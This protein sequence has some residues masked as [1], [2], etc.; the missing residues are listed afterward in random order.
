MV[1]TQYHCIIFKHV[2]KQLIHILSMLLYYL[3]TVSRKAFKNKVFSI[4]NII[5]LTIGITCCIIAFLYLQDEL[6]YDKHFKNIENVYRLTGNNFNGMDYQSNQPVRFMQEIEQNIPEIKESLCI[7]ENPG[8]NVGLENKFRIENNYMWAGQNFFT[9]LQ[10]ELIRGRPDEVL[11]MPYSVTISE[12]KARE[13][14]GDKDPIGQILRIDNEYNVT[15]TGVFK[16]FPEQSHISADFIESTLTFKETRKSYFTS[17]GWFSSFL[18][19]KTI[20]LANTKVVNEKITKLWHASSQGGSQKASV[21]ISLQRFSDIYLRSGSLNAEQQYGDIYKVIGFALIAA[22][23]LII[24]CFNFIN[25]SIAI[26]GQRSVES[27]VKKT[28]GAGKRFLSGQIVAEVTFYATVSLILSQF[29]ITVILPTFNNFTGKHLNSF[30]F[31]NYQLTI[32]IILLTVVIIT[33]TSSFPAS[34]L[35]K[36]NTASILKCNNIFNHYKGR[37]LL[38]PKNNLQSSLVTFQFF[39]GIFLVL[40]VIIINKQL[41]FIRT[42]EIGF[43][44]EQI[45]V[46]ENYEKN[47][48]KNYE[49]FKQQ[50]RKYPEVQMISSGINVP[51]DGVWN[52]GG[53]QLFNNP[54]KQVSGCGFVFVDYNYLTLLGTK[55]LKGR[56]FI[57]G[58]NTDLDKVIVTNTFANQL[59]I[60]QPIGARLTN[61]FDDKD[62]EIIGVVED[63]EFKSAHDKMKPI[64]FTCQTNFYTRLILI[65]LQTNNLLS[66]VNAIKKTWNDIVPESP[67][68]YSFMDEKFNKNYKKEMQTAIVINALTVIA[69]FLCCMGLFALVLFTINSK[70]KEIGIRRVNGAKIW[71]IMVL[72]NKNFIQGVIIAFILACPIAWYA[73]NKWLQRFAYRTELNWWIFAEAGMVALIIALITVS[74]QS[75]RAATKNPVEALRYE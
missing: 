37:K 33:L 52:W 68:V 74:W 48:L 24:S 26:I 13:Y 3:K 27:G 61:L 25:L 54:D 60:D 69:V 43:N 62:R 73:M 46:I 66:T 64:V 14:F 75:W 28:F 47:T 70:I 45:M 1:R 53:P 42:K 12:T 8:A 22:L 23:I 30:I 32:F 4:I 57:E 36:I 16:D 15:I 65:K 50:V 41:R 58:N 29:L 9:F 56:N 7:K 19:L 39:I 10:W 34:I 17:W 35:A 20:P 55:F 38:L 72:L 11:T 5:G 6:K 44:K 63:I 31:Q 59:N 49:V 18:Y 67:I 21:K 51:F 40:S 71:E 2:Q